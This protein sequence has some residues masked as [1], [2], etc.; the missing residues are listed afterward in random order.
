MNNATLLTRTATLFKNHLR[1]LL[2][3][4]LFLSA[5][6]PGFTQLQVNGRFLYNKC[7]QKVIIRGI[8]HMLY[9]HD[10]NQAMLPEIGKTGANAIRVML[11]PALPASTLRQILQKCIN[12]Q[13][14]YVSVAPWRGSDIWFRSDIKTVLQEFEDY[15]IIHAFGEAPY[16][17][18]SN[19]SR[20]ISETTSLITRIRQAGYKAPLDIQSTTYGRDPRPVIR[21]GQAVLNADPLRNIIFGVQLYWG[22]WYTGLYGMSIAQACQQFAA[23]P[24]PV[25][26]GACPSDCNTACGNMAWDESYKNELGCMWWCWTGDEF[27][28]SSNGNFNQLTA[29]GQYIINNSPYSMTKTSVRSIPCTASA[30]LALNRPAFS[31]SNETGTL[32]APKAV[33]GNI[34]TR[35]SSAFSDPQWIYVDLGATY[36]L[37]RVVLRWE[38]AYGRAYQVQTSTN[39]STWTTRFTTTTGNGATD[40]ITLSGSGRYVRIYGT[41]RFNTGWGYS[42]WEIEVYGTS[43]AAR[44]AAQE[45]VTMEEE[46]IKEESA[47]VYPN[48]VQ[49]GMLE[50]YIVSKKKQQAT[51][52][53]KSGSGQ[54]VAEYKKDLIKGYNHLS[55]PLKQTAEGMYFLVIRKDGKQTTHKVIINKN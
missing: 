38:A 37:T 35:W 18:T 34:S 24:Y 10:Q 14:M 12:D 5:A 40:D 54:S 39:A 8:E 55:L 50:V 26:V 9:Y 16:E 6:Q 13:K 53:L 42:L 21:S 2:F 1:L 7:G 15:I 32:N 4:F 3:I 27:E 30:N 28:L 44:A 49:S 51:L 43:S 46:E 48:P 22:D 33:D 19:D 29:D 41:Q 47:T 36:N 11:D 31:S 17:T 20:W 23:L 52:T 25:Q 45:P